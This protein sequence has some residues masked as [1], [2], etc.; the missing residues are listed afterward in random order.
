M[1]DDDNNIIDDLKKELNAPDS[2]SEKK[3]KKGTLN[4]RKT[5]SA[6]KKRRK[7]IKDRVDSAGSKELADKRQQQLDAAK[8]ETANLREL[9]N[10]ADGKS[11]I[12]NEET[13]NSVPP[14]ARSFIEEQNVVWKPH[15]GVQT[16]FLKSNEDEVLFA[17]GRGSGKSDCLMVDPL[18]F[19]T[20]RNFRGL[21]IR[22]SMPELRELIFRAKEIYPIAYPKTQWK[23]QEKIFIFPSGA[24]IEFGYCDNLDDLERYRGQ[25][26]TWL[27]I[28]E[29]TQFPDEMLIERLKGSLRTIDPTL[30]IYI[31][32]TCN[33]SGAGR[34]WVKRRW[35][36]DKK[37][38]GEPWS[39]KI[40]VPK[41]EFT[42]TGEMTITRKW[43]NST[44]RD[45]PTLLENNPQYIASLASIANETLRR[46]WLEG[47]WYAA[48]GL[49]F[50]DFDRRKHVIEPFPV[51]K[52]W[53]K[54]RACDWGYS[55]MSVCL[56]FAVSPD[57]VLYVYREYMVDG[58]SVHN[59]QDPE[60]FS[61]ALI[62]I[63]FEAE[64][65]ISYGILDGSTWSTRGEMGETA[66]E[67]MIRM[68]LN[69]VRADRSPGSRKAGKLRLHTYLAK[70]KIKIFNTCPE[71]IKELESLMLD[72][73]NPEDVDKSKKTSIPDHAYDALRYGLLSR[74]EQG[75]RSYTPFL[76][77]DEPPIDP[78]FGY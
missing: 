59:R 45:N 19:C 57:N 56:W 14:S 67:T 68:G 71:L 31:R 6:K 9:I 26:Y 17:G 47:D 7:I 37:K 77:S 25:Q 3:N 55:S 38:S 5:Y 16:E 76:L 46:Q 62:D 54:F 39:E 23:E 58:S 48:E 13:L 69:W 61:R 4:L 44:V 32:A 11:G 51:P 72:P 52:E 70:D 43:F 29:I 2:L 15:E 27:G 42:P 66:A 78:F 1:S 64:E 50:D 34:T 33:P 36:T 12:V 24:R 28:D 21:I 74:P 75:I 22:R 10:V 60:V 63:E 53:Y 30:K 8:K 73:N 18:R 35:K 20:N 65:Y 49:A 40:P 41:T